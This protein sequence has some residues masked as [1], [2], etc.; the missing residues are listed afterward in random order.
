MFTN[1]TWTIG[2]K[3]GAAFGAV[4]L[5]FALAL[6][7]TLLYAAKANSHWTEVQAIT[8]ANESAGAQREGT[9]EQMSAQAHMVATMD[10]KFAADFEKGVEAGDAGSKGVEKLHDATISRISASAN[11]ADHTHDATINEELIPAVKRGDKVAALAALKKADAA[12]GVVFDKLE[13]IGDYVEKRQSAAT[14]NAQAAT[15]TA[16]RLGIISGLLAVVLAAAAALFVVR[17]IRRG[18]TAILERLASLTADADALA[19]ALDAASTGDLTTSVSVHTAAIE[20]VSSDEIGQVATAVNTIRDRTEASV[21]SYNR[22]VDGLRDLVTDVSAS[23]STVASSSQQMASTSDEAGRA[24][25]EI[26]NAVGDVAQGAERQVRMVETTRQAVQEAATAAGRSAETARETS[27]AAEQARSVA[28]EGVM[29]AEQATGAIRGV[30]DSSAQVASAIEDLSARSERIGGIV[31]TITG[32]AEQTNLLAL[33]A[34][35]EAAR[36]GEQGRGFAVVAEEVRKLAE[37]SQDA[38][39]QIAGLIGE[40]QSETQ[41]VVGVVADGA[42]R[43]EDGVATVEQA[44]EA[45]EQIGDAVEQV[46]SRVTEIAA[47]VEQITAE[48]DRAQSGIGEVAAVAEQ[49]SASAEQV[50]ASTQQTSAS[51]QEIAASAQELARTAE[52]LEQLVSRFRVAA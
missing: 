10:P 30:A 21:E 41:K 18:V 44:R 17:G 1:M 48:A 42:K 6:T 45:F 39:G 47:A 40:I 52:Q 31:D 34:A 4:C 22:M 5:L 33:N 23:A 11:S 15:A 29:A 3:L 7:A 28:R 16:R 49:S 20:R 43:T 13:S 26:A 14:A 9:R 50:S 2:R 38:A 25:G 24:V 37:E 19:G 32:I 46:S 36:A 8:E 12:V 35:I 27:Q 51:T